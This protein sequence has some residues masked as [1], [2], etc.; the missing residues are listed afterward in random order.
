VPKQK[1]TKEQKRIEREVDA[2]CQ[3]LSN[4]HV[5]NIMDLDKIHDAG[6]AAG[7]AGQDINAAVVAAIEQYEVKL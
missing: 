3:K 6:M 4:G 2:A 1:L 7:N 5:I